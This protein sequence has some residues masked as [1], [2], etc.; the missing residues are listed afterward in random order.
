MT[1]SNPLP[2]SKPFVA[3]RLIIAFARSASSLSNTGAPS[4]RGHPRTMHVT[5]PPHESPLT[6]TSS[7]ASII[8]SALASFGQ[9]AMLAS[10]SSMVTVAWSTPSATHVFDLRDVRQNLRA[11][12]LLQHLLGDGAGGD[13][14]DGLPRGRPPAARDGAHAVLHVV[15]GVRVRGAVRH[16]D[17]A[18]ILRP[19]ILV[20]H[21]HRD[22]RAERHAVQADAGLKSRTCPPRREGW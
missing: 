21:E 11:G 17:L 16:R 5:T 13:A 22:G 19:V 1:P 15:R 6:R 3:G 9:R 7:M 2:T 4:P 8:L 12:D 20:A 18:V 14:P 10:T